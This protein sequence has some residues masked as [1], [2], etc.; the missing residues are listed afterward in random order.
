MKRSEFNRRLRKACAHKS[1]ALKN[2]GL[3]NQ[4]KIANK[5][6][7]APSH[8]MPNQVEIK[9]LLTIEVAANK[10]NS[11]RQ[12]EFEKYLSLELKLAC[13]EG[14]EPR[15]F[16]TWSGDSRIRRKGERN[17]ELHANT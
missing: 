5:R 13:S 9:A 12:N 1:S 10:I 16:L 2:R 3:A 7:S 4:L 17:E 14:R 11:Q 8:T 15:S 6:K